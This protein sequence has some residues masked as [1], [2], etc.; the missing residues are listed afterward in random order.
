MYTFS[1]IKN[2]L[3]ALNEASTEL[4]S[5]LKKVHKLGLELQNIQKDVIDL[6]E[7]RKKIDPKSKT[8]K[9]LEAKINSLLKTKV[10]IEKEM[11]RETRKLE[12][13]ISQLDPQ[14]KIQKFFT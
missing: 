14:G 11:D 9:K 8:L 3:H 2:G 7:D 10:N 1:D 6:Y 4:N 5:S 12:R 13:L